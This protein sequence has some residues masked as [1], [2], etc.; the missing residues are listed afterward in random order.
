MKFYI[1]F[2]KEWYF[3]NIGFFF[4]GENKFNYSRKK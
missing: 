4:F 2:R 3:I 1:D